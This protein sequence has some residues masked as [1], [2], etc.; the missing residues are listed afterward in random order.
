[1]IDEP[2]RELDRVAAETSFSGAVR[3]DRDG[4]I[5]VANTSERAWPVA[6]RLTELL[7]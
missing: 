7:D 6:R 5:D 2:R 1:M 3:V 4:A